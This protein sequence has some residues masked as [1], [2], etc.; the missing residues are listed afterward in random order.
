[1]ATA[2]GS[3]FAEAS[4]GIRSLASRSSWHQDKKLVA[5]F[6]EYWYSP[7]SARIALAS[8]SVAHFKFRK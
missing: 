2:T 6:Q 1:M 5:G 7:I 8:T 3:R 4:A